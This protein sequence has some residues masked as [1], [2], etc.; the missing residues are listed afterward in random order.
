M[1]WVKGL[2]NLYQSPEQRMEKYY[3]CRGLGQNCAWAKRMRDWRWTKLYRFFNI[4][5]PK[6]A[7]AASTSART[8]EKGRLLQPTRQV[9]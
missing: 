7:G 5:I 4:P 1:S 8:T 9:D 6:Y 2:V 3:F